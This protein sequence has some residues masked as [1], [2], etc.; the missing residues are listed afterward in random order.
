MIVVSKQQ[1]IAMHHALV[2]ETGGLDGL[3]DEGLLDSAIAAPFQTF[4]STEL[5]Q[6]VHEKAARLG[7]G[8]VQ[9]HPFLDGNK[10]IGAHAMLVFLALNGISLFYTQDELASVFLKMAAGEIDYDILL[11]WVIDHEES[12]V[13]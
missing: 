4:D 1:I 5:F 6:S 12:D 10:R 8:L 2:M 3:R 13:N 11:Q 7:C 9:N